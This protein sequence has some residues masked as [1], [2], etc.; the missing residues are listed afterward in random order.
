M[1]ESFGNLPSGAKSIETFKLF[2]P[3]ASLDGFSQ[4]LRLSKIPQ[5]TWES[6]QEDRRYGVTMAWLTSAKDRWLNGFDW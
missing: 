1:S 6:T 2:I 4:L 5:A 3:D